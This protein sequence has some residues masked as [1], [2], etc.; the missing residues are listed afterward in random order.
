[1]TPEYSQKCVEIARDN[2]D[3]VMG[4]IAQRSLNVEP[5]DNFITMTPGCQLPP[6]GQDGEKLGDKLGQQYNTPRKL[7]LD[8]GCDVIIVGRGIVRAANPAAEAARYQAE[9]WNA[10]EERVVIRPG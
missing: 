9:G 1:M 4:F 7:I 8:Q 3:F 10:Y 6:P 5:E 2:R